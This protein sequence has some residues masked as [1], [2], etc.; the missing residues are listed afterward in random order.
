MSE[1]VGPKAR[2]F[3]EAQRRD[4]QMRAEALPDHPTRAS[5]VGK[6]PFRGG[7][8]KFRP[9][10]I[11]EA[12][13]ELA[14]HLVADGVLHLREV[15]HHAVGVKTASHGDNQARSCAP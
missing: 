9:G 12:E 10:L 8:V 13:I 4:R 3:V 7:N 6:A 5:V 15:E 14:R 1:I 11:E 2:L